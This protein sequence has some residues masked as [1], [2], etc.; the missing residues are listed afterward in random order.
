M[1]QV[2]KL[3]KQVAALT[4]T[5]AIPAVRL[6]ARPFVSGQRFYVYATFEQV[7]NQEFPVE[8]MMEAHNHQVY[9]NIPTDDELPDCAFLGWVEVKYQP[10]ADSSIWS[11]GHGGSMFRVIR[12]GIFEHPID[13]QPFKGNLYESRLETAPVFHLHECYEPMDWGAEL[14]LPVNGT[15]FSTISRVGQITLDLFGRLASCVLDDDGELKPFTLLTLT[16][17]N[18]RRSFNF[19]GEIVADLDENCEP[20]LYPSLLDPTGYD[21]RK[22]LFLDCGDP[23][24]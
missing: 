16:C 7:P 14:E 2:I 18:R 19:H 8:W 24:R 6:G 10:Y 12:R 1:I 13:L 11:Y 4:L 23:R 21:I 15:L 3:P 17:G 9:G 22:R 20:V 5:D